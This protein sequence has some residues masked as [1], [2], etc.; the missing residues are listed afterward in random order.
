M[1][2]QEKLKQILHYDPDTGIFTNLTQR[3]STAKK[4][5]IAGSKH[6]SG[7][8]NI[9]IDR[10]KYR[11]HRLAWLYIHGEFPETFLDHKNENPR[12]NS[13]VNLRVATEQQNQHNKSKP[14][15]TN[16]CGLL[17][18]SWYTPSKKWRAQIMLNGKSKHLGLFNTAEEA[19]TAYIAAKRQYHNFWIENKDD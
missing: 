15:K 2:T 14:Y 17:G 9:E 7:Y 13:I 4:G 5:S 1:L 19:S 10:K 18:V 6:A 8:I 3:S 11:A 12:D 16:G